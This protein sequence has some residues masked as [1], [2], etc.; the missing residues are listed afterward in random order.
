MAIRLQRRAGDAQQAITPIATSRDGLGDDRLTGKLS[1]LG[2]RVD[3]DTGTVQAQ[4]T[5]DN[6]QALFLPGQFVRLTLDGLVLPNLLAVPEIAV[7]EG[8]EGPQVYIVDADG[9]AKPVTV[10]LGERSGAWIALQSGIAAGQRVVVSNVASAQPGRAIAAQPFDG[11]A[12]STPPL[13]QQQNQGADQQPAQG[14]QNAA[15]NATQK[16]SRADGGQAGGGESGNTAKG[17]NG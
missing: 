5:F 12:D 15:Q 3:P 7:L 14:A 13:V 6:P 4:A 11:K 17:A 10:E 2:S 9:K 8:R 1:F 16:G